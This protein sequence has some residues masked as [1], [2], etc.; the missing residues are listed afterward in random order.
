MNLT[1]VK[2]GNGRTIRAWIDNWNHTPTRE[3]YPHLYSFSNDQDISLW[4]LKE[5]ISE[6]FY[7]HFYT[8][9][10]I[11]ADDE[12]NEFQLALENVADDAMEKD[13]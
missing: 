3:E 7:D 9:L 5:I 11:I 1:N 8:P 6:D 2:V 10:S 13:I 4:R 12:G